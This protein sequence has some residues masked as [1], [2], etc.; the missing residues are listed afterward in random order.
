[1]LE[2]SVFRGPL[3]NLERTLLNVLFLLERRETE[4]REQESQCII[5]I[6]KLTK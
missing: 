2:P 5:I 3:A 1:M 6:F 4:L